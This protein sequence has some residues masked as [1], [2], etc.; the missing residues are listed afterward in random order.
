MPARQPVQPETT[1]PGSRRR[2]TVSLN[3]VAAPGKG[4]RS[5]PPLVPNLRSNHTARYQADEP[6]ARTKHPRAGAGQHTGRSSDDCR[7]TFPPNPVPF[8]PGELQAQVMSD[9]G[10]GLT[11]SA[12]R[13]GTGPE[14]FQ[15]GLEPAPP[16][17]VPRAMARPQERTTGAGTRG[18]QWPA[19]ESGRPGPV[20]YAG[21]NRDASRRN[22][23]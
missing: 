13:P 7:W 1:P 14:D 17:G 11:A 12:K 8:S 21:V 23:A 6:I 10:T 5:A 2:H 22:R 9:L 3:E 19:P 15:G 18:K 4:R 16:R 20:M